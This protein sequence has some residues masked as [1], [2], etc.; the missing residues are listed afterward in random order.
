LS[1]SAVDQAR[2]I[3]YWS[4][5]AATGDP[6]AAPGPRWPEFGSPAR[7]H[8][9][10]LAPDDIGPVDLAADHQCRFFASR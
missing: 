10:S 3:G 2:M 8:V 4:A 9:L 7:P 6:N 1:L 5:F